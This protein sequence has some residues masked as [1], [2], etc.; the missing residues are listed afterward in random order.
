MAPSTRRPPSR[1]PFSKT[2]L[3]ALIPPAKGREY[4]YDDRKPGLALCLTAAGGKIW[5][6]Y[7]KIDGRPTR[8]RIA[9]Y[10][11]LSLENARKT[12]DAMALKVAA[13]ENPQTAKRQ[14]REEATLG[15]LWVKW[16]DYA[17]GH[18]KTWAEDEAQWN[19]YLK[20]WEN[21]RLS[22]VKKADVQ[23]LHARIGKDNG[24]YAANRALALL[25]AM[26]NKADEIGWQKGNPCSK[27]KSFKEES[28]DRFIQAAEM[29]RFFQA[30]EEEPSPVLRGFFL[31][32]L[33]TGARR[34]NVQRM[35]W[36]HIDLGNSLWRIPDTK[37]GEPQ[38]I[39]LSPVAL[40]VVV[41]LQPE[42]KDG[43]VFPAFR[44]GKVGHLSDP[45]P[46][47]RRICK[48]AGLKNLRI[49]DLRRSMGSW[50]ALGGSSLQI[51]GKALGHTRPETTA[52]YSRLEVDPI[53]SAINQA[54]ASMLTAGGLLEGPRP[55]ELFT[56]KESH[57]EG[58]QQ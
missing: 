40:Q 10:R 56:E 28:R 45:M 5:Y 8:V 38:V 57:G 9:G 29:P 46:A 20:R 35:R 39:P 37:R 26:F 32:C 15:D 33:L 18:K 43:W 47:W 3:D 6:Y 16:L 4:H 42:S 27:I 22:T 21:R 23:S 55:H 48:R 58:S 25:R 49:H 11:E 19:R 12:V 7:R 14:R 52:I 17:K 13:G 24:R 31:T 30:L 53:R 36:E 51:I 1:F 50:M 2:R 54:T 34:G 41:A 44:R